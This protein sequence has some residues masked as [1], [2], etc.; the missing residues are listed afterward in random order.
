MLAMQYT[1]VLPDDH[2]MALIRER[3]RA[4]GPL[5][6][7]FDG[8]L[9][10]SYLYACRGE[11]GPRNLYA[12]FYVWRDT[13]GM[14]RFLRGPGFAALSADFGRP[15]VSLWAVSRRAGGV[16]LRQARWATLTDEGAEG[17]TS[18]RPLPWRASPSTTPGAGAAAASRSGGTN[19]RRRASGS[20]TWR[21]PRRRC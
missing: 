3:I 2:D 9:F 19:R 18:C 7:G 5:L 16:D 14:D 1:I 8:L 21:R 20:A 6:D 12:P 17:A 13:A 15:A 4:K 10:K 11:D